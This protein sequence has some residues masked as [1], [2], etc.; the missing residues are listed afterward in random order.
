MAMKRPRRQRKSDRLLCPDATAKEIQCDYSIAPLDRLALVMDHKWGIDRLPELVSVEMAQ[1]YGT[2]MA[3][4]NDCIREADP[5][6]CAA[7]AQNCM[8]GLNAM[9]A[10]A[11][12][13]GQPQASGEYW[14][15]ELPATDG[16][17]PFKFAIMRDGFEWRT[18]QAVRPD[19]EFYTMREAAIALQTYVRSPLLSEVK[20]QFPASEIIKIKPPVDFAAGGDP[21][22]F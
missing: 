10:E 18:A 13:A 6:K 16:N 17:P 3:H 4:L 22:P 19:L 5:A 2:A 7:A 11:T 20:K 12:A 14:E 1:R 21:I 8:R 15:Y 9:D